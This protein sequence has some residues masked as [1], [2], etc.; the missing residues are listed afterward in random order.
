[1]GA[2]VYLDSHYLSNQIR[3]VLRSPGRLALWL[4]YIIGVGALTFRRFTVGATRPPGLTGTGPHPLATAA[5]GAFIGMLGVT[6]VVAASGRI[7]AFRST[8]EALLLVNAG[9]DSLSI[10]VWLQIRKLFSTATRWLGSIL[11]VFLLIVPENAGPQALGRGIVASLA[12]AASIMTVELPAFLLARKP[13][14]WIVGAIGW[15]FAAVGALYAAVGFLGS[16]GDDRFA[17]AILDFVR[18]NPGSVVPVIVSSWAG[19]LLLWCAPLALIASI[20]TLARD[21]IPELY[22]ATVQAF[23]WRAR[24]RRDQP[25]SSTASGR[26]ERIPAGALA[27]VWKDWIGFTRSRGAPFRWLCVFAAWLGLGLLVGWAVT[28]G[29]R[30]DAFPLVGFAMMVIVLV[31]LSASISLVEDL[32]KPIWWMSHAS[33]RSRIVAWAFAKGWRNGLAFAVFPLVVA[34]DKI[35]LASG[36]LAIPLGLCLWTSLN[37]LGVA[38]Y[39]AYPSRVDARGPVFFVRA[40]ATGLFLLPP[41]ILFGFFSMLTRNAQLSAALATF[42]LGIEGW[43]AIEFAVYRFKENGAGISMLERA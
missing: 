26:V 6:I 39:A 11:F 19:P 31:P 22:A 8:G 10:A 1:M 28:G 36:L 4:P 30:A 18:W 34:I 16:I 21:A 25:V 9:I 2:L 17:P 41:A 43:I 37:A 12:V 15:T 27:I 33:L 3:A 20:A 5:A 35:D 24:Q 38:L 7:R 40:I 13:A 14:G 29:D 23:E 42:C 32:S